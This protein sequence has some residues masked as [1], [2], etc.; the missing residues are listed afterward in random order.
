MG[1]KSRVAFAPQK[2]EALTPLASPRQHIDGARIGNDIYVVGG[3]DEEFTAFDSVFE[4]S[5]R[6]DRS[7]R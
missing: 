4:G 7:D 6:L 1:F 2:W 3:C 5:I